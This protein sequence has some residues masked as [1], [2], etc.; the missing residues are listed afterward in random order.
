MVFLSVSSSNKGLN[1]DEIKREGYLPMQSARLFD[2]QL[3]TN[4]WFKYGSKLSKFF[5]TLEIE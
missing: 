4:L 2:N 1:E 5:Q 3:V